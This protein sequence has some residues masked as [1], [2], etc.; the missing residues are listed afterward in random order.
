M[1][2]VTINGN[3]GGAVFGGGLVTDSAVNFR[4]V[5]A[6]ILNANWFDYILATLPRYEAGPENTVKDAVFSSPDPAIYTD[7]DFTVIKTRGTVGT[8]GYESSNPSVATVDVEGHV[9]H[10]VDGQT[11]ITITSLARTVTKVLTFA[12]QE[13]TPNVYLRGAPG[14]LRLHLEQQITGRIADITFADI[15]NAKLLYSTQNHGSG[16]YVRNTAC[17]AKT[18]DLTCCSVWN[19]SGG[20]QFAGTLISP[21]HVLFASHYVG[22]SYN[23]SLRFVAQDGTLVTRQLATIVS[24]IAGTDLAVGVLTEDVPNTITFAKVLPVNW[25]SYLPDMPISSFLITDVTQPG[26]MIDQERK[27][28]V[29]NINGIGSYTT[30]ANYP[31]D[32]QLAFYEQAISGDSGNPMFMIV[33][34]APVIMC[35]LLFA[36]GGPSVVNYRS[37]LNAVMASLDAT[38]H[39]G[40]TAKQLTPVDLSSFNTY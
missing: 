1:S 24:G 25:N 18:I 8:I 32:P 16:I 29:V 36:N 39:P 10:L 21:R 26:V 31:V 14:S 15:A 38:Y 27:A 22:G 37:Q 23:Y 33:N 19:T 7:Y 5:D 17:W 35:A 11:T 6:G 4:R 13:G 20:N 30:A 28:L 3:L 2:R 34:N 12:M 9:T 40:Q